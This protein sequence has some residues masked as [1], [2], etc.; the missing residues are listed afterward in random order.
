MTI[1]AATPKTS[2]AKERTRPAFPKRA[3]I[4]GGMPYGNKDLHFGHV[5]GVFVQADTFARFLRDR[6]GADNVIFVS[7][8]DCY[9]SP[10]VE[11]HREMTAKGEFA[12][13]LQ[14]MVERN[15]QR[16][17]QTLAD[18]HVHPSLFAASSVSPYR[19]IHEK[20]GADLLT[21][22]HKHGLV[23]KMTNLQ[24]F[25]G[26]LNVFLNGRQ[27]R[28]TCPIQG[29]QSD[30]AYADECSLGHQY[31]PRDLVN[32][33]SSLTGQ[34][35]QMQPVSNWYVD[36]PR[37]RELLNAWL[38]ELREAGQWRPFVI[39]TLQEWLEPPTIHIT[40]DQIEKLSEVA[41]TLPAHSQQEGRG[42]S[43]QLV[44][45]E[46]EP[47]EEARH[48]LGEHGIR[49]RTGKTLVPFR[50]TGNLTW[51]LKA[52]TIDG[53][54]DVTF[55]VWPE[56]LW[57]PISF[58]MA[59][60]ES[61]GAD[62]KA[63][64]QWWCEKDAAIYQFIGEDNIYF[65][66]IAQGAMWLGMQGPQ[67]T[68]DG[69]AGA[70]QMSHL[71]ANR[72]ILFLDKKASSSGAVKPPLASELLNFYTADQLRTH[73][74]SLG[75]GMRSTSFRPKPLDPN[76]DE[77]QGDPVLK[78]GNLIS[79][80]FNRAVRSCFYT[81]QKF[82]EGKIPVGEVSA[83]VLEFCEKQILDFEA[84]MFAHEFHNTVSIAGD[85][86]RD[87][88][89]RWTKNKPYADDGEPAL[90]NQTL[91]DAFHMVRVAAVLMHPIAPSGTEMIREYLQVG[92][93]FWDWSRV[94]DTV[95]A[96]MAEPS[97]H[98][99]K[100]LEPRVDF[101]PKHPSQVRPVEETQEG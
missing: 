13:T 71:V 10:I 7:G 87:I 65:Y 60:L 54:D 30:K 74:F 79:N 84:A 77:R 90:R 64:K 48:I 85:L 66:G 44:F 24:F 73:F 41:D 18:Y 46:L 82:C 81:A 100:T 43:L 9:G 98:T 101:F 8:T 12:G 89:A 4:T 49:Y 78:E 31:E 6:I 22:L 1:D 72:H 63:W 62:A 11:Q 47:M 75:L 27:V 2:A 26:D 56:S 97:T 67:P 80:A 42:K 33:I 23:T 35:P 39:S 21:T 88:N 99:L 36:V 70:L 61:K 29:C 91:I 17:K 38:K 37:L 14:E 57:A 52:P 15:H 28:G 45:R 55:W 69:P 32:P 51:G 76:A 59:Y 95:Y 16:Q 68:L 19:E 93:E 94:F 58:T 96:F 53:L 50:L 86:I 20:L 34:T 92:P 25:D 83:D 3:V 40:K 5:G